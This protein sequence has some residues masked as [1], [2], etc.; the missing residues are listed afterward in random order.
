MKQN[1]TLDSSFWIN[2][3]RAGLLPYLLDRYTLHYAPEVA[4]EL[5]E[6]FLSGGEF[7]RLAREGTLVQATARLQPFQAFGQGE[8]SAINLT[9][10]HRNWFILIDDRRPFLEAVRLGLK[11]VSTPLLVVQLFSEG[12]LNASQALESLAHLAVLQTVSPELLTAAL[13]YLDQIL[14]NQG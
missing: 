7:W 2:A 8:R 13:A 12:K 3:H 5:R 4:A 9:L 10:E 11:A 14:K 6:S 1:A